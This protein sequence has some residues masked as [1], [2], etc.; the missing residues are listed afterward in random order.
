[1]VLALNQAARIMPSRDV[2]EPHVSRQRPEEGNA[3]ADEHRHPRN[4][5]TLNQPGA[6]EF[7][8][9]D[10][11]VDV[12]IVDPSGRE[13]RHDLRRCPGHLFDRAAGDR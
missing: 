11:A 3:L 4:H 7:L 6:Q 10:P 1:M 2:E 13:L 8:N 5:E 9:R 12:Q